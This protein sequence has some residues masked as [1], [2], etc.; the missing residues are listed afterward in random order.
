MMMVVMVMSVVAITPVAA[1]RH[2]TVPMTVSMPMSG[3]D[4]RGTSQ[5]DCSQHHRC[6][7]HE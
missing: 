6:S 7:N 4:R 3:F 2:A 1:K 5:A